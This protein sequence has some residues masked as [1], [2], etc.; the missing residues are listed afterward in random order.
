MLSKAHQDVLALFLK[1]GVQVS[2]G[3]G[4]GGGSVLISVLVS[5]L[6]SMLVSVLISVLIGFT[7]QSTI[8]W[9]LWYSCIN[10]ICYSEAGKKRLVTVP[11]LCP[12]FSLTV[13]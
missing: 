4:G 7:R 13:P 1:Q 8:S 9:V 12:T 11:Y 6:V 10:P 2:R 3:V 5:V